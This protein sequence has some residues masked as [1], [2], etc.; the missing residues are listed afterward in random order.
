MKISHNQIN[1]ISIFPKTI[2]CLFLLLLLTQP[3]IANSNNSDSDLLG[4]FSAKVKNCEV[5]LIWNTLSETDLKLFEIEWSGD[6][7]TF[8]KIHTEYTSGFSPNI[9]LYEFIDFNSLYSN[10]YRLKMI[11]FDGT[12]KYSKIISA[13][14]ECKGLNTLSVFPNPVLVNSSIINLEFIPTRPQAQILI[15]DMLGRTIQRLNFDTEKGIANK[16]QLDISN[17]PAGTYNMIVVGER[18]AK[19]FVI[20]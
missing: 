16:F 3:S 14:K 8:N 15:N 18:Q 19:I 20:K 13:K 17:Y 7:Q 6:G 1:L 10:F 4:R 12:F 9:G 5:K 2:Y 11:N